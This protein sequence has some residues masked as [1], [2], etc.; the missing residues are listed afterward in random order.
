MKKYITRTI[1]VTS[2]T[3]VCVNAGTREIKDIDVLVY[4]YTEDDKEFKKCV[5]SFVSLE[6][7]GEFSVVSICEPSETHN[8]LIRMPVEFFAIYGESRGVVNEAE[9]L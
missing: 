6:T 7:N 3:A 5:D 8:E 2:V 9:E 4:G 1:P